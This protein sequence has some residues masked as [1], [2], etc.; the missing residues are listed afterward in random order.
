M[1][2]L[3]TL[4]PKF[5]RRPAEEVA[6]D[7]LGRFVIRELDGERLILRI[8][9]VEAYLGA[10]DRASHAWNGR[11]TERNRSLYEDGG[12]AY[13]YFIYGMNFCLN[14][15]TGRRGNGDAVLLRAGEPLRGVETMLQHRGW[16]RLPRPGDV[17]GGPGKLCQALK[18][19]RALDG[20]SL[21]QGSLRF[22]EGEPVSSEE[23]VTGS[24]IGI[25]Y[26]GD[27]ATWPLRFAVRGN[28]HV[29]R[30]LPRLG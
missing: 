2:R 19:D 26:A 21:S 30:P 7:L 12:V 15:V 18:V 28:P 8:V 9:E 11:C 1:G 17:A 6:P 3:R 27:A 25:G 23:I 10:T 13:V 22:T 4:P 24:R 20:A 16:S 14:A 29:S 5:Y